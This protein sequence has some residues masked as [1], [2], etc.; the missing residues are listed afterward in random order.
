MF[1]ERS[2]FR[3]TVA[4]L[5]VAATISAGAIPAAEPNADLWAKRDAAVTRSID[6][7]AKNQSPDGSWSPQ[8]GAAVTAMVVAG[9]L[10]SGRSADDPAV[11]KGL[12]Y[13]EK[14]VQPDGGIYTPDGNYKNYETALA[15]AAF[16][17]ANKDGRYKE[18][19]VGGEKFG[20]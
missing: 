6:F 9:L 16:S 4:G 19:L 17:E 2:F 18:L 12:K 8:T 20:I 11:A 10:R 14:F 1:R 3:L 7:L 13:L 5:V 15:I